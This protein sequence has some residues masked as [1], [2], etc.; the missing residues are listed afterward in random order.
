MKAIPTTMTVMAA[1]G[2]ADALPIRGA[3]ARHM[4]QIA[5]GAARNRLFRFGMVS[6]LLPMGVTIMESS[7]ISASNRSR[8]KYR[9]F[10]ITRMQESRARYSKNIPHS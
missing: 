10:P 3:S 5:K 2:K 8:L 4:P 7:T 1:A 6:L 9:A